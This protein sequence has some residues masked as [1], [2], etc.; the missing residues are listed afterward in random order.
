[1]RLAAI[2]II[3]SGVLGL[4]GN[5]LAFGTTHVLGQNAEHERITRH[6]LACVAPDGPD[7]QACFKPKAIAELAGEGG[8]FGAVGAPDNPVNR[9]LND[10]KSHCD[11]GDY[12]DAPGY[13]RLQSEAQQA[14][15]ACRAYM[16]MK[17]NEAVD[18]A[19]A[20]VKD[21]KLV[22]AEIPTVIGCSFTFTKSR[23]WCDV[24][25]DFGVAL[26]TA[27]DFYAH[28]NW[29]D[30][31]DATKPVSIDNPPGLGQ[32]GR[33][34]W[35]D[36]RNDTPF[37]DGLMTGCFLGAMPK[38]IS[39]CTGRVTHFVLNKDEGAIDP[40]LGAGITTRGATDD[41]FAHAVEAAVEDTRD[42]WDYLRGLLVQR[43]GAG[44]GGRI[45]CALTNGK[46]YKS[47]CL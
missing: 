7:V 9:R 5:A 16:I 35:F 21:G 43:Y 18:D 26:H 41:N 44:D 12:L 40:A 20:L 15:I 37:P 32:H 27:Q 6:A 47:S 30:T 36:P 25:E 46:D 22:D 17:L 24:I 38:G 1:M 13:P 8:T 34:P 19:A 10:A 29:V 2:A 11:N 42:K 3:V 31:A 14:L 39:G 28:S 45:V 23:A 4:A 33:A